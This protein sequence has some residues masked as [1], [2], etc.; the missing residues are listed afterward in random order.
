M[1]NVE[2]INNLFIRTY[3]SQLEGHTHNYHQVLMPL[4]G[5][6]SMIIM[7]QTIKVSYGET[8][9]IRKGVY[10]QFQARKDFRF[11]VANIEDI[12]FLKLSLNETHFS[13]DEKTLLY[14]SFVEKQLTSAYNQKIEGMMFELLKEL[15]GTIQMTKRLDTRLTSVV[16]AIKGN[17]TIN[18]TIKS[19][20]EIACLSESQFKVLFKE[21]LGCTPYA[22]IT[23]LRMK[24]ALGLILN[25]DT[26]IAIVAEKC[27]YDN[28]SAFIR[29]FSNFYHQTPYKL[30]CNNQ[31]MKHPIYSEQF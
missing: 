10:H 8:L 4:M 24:S 26:P 17:I 18:H 31:D 13:M 11:L 3:D 27:G 2:L 25:T 21:Y 14:I 15:L 19:L 1:K 7:N 6:I 29:R 12:D 9:V 28:V 20:A 5:D 22:Y 23:E 30:R 16:Q